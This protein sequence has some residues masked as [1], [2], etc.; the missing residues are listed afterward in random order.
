[1][2]T[3][4]GNNISQT[5]QGLIKLANSTT[6]VTSTTQSFQDG[7]GNNIPIQVSA[8]QV[9]ISGSFFINNVPITNG[10]NGTSGTSGAAGSSGSSGSS[11]ASGSSG[12][13]GSGG[14]SGTS[15]SDGTSGSNGSS[16]SSGSSGSDGSSGTSGS[17]GSDGSSGS[18]GSSG[19]DGSSGTSGSNGTDGTSGSSGV[20]NSFFNYQAKTTITSGNPGSGHIIWDNATQTGS[21]QI[22]ISDIDQQSNNLDVFLSQLKSGSRITLQDKLIQG[23]YQVWDIGTS[24]DNTSYWS[25]PVT[26]V[27]STYQFTNNEDLLF[28]ITTTPSG[29]SGSSGTAGTSGTSPADL[30]RA[31][32]I[33]TGSIAETQSITGSLIISG[34]N[35]T[36]SGSLDINGT[37]KITGSLNVSGS[38]QYDINLNGQMLISNMDTNSTRAP[39]IFLSG[40]GGNTTINR[41]S[42]ATTNTTFTA[43]LNPFATFA[44]KNATLDEIGFTVDSGSVSGWTKGPAIYT[45]DPTDNFPAMIGF[46]DKA[47]YTDG[48]ITLLKNTDITGSLRTTTGIIIDNKLSISNGNNSLLSNIAIGSSSLSIIPNTRTNN[49]AIGER[50]LTVAYAAF[51]NTAIS[52]GRK[53]ENANDNTLIGYGAGDEIQ[54]CI[55]ENTT[56]GVYSLGTLISGSYNTAI[57]Y[58]AGYEAKGDNNL[59]LGHRAGNLSTGSNTLI[60]DSSVNGRGNN[61]SLIYG[62]FDA[63]PNN[64]ILRINAA[65]TLNGNT[66]ITGSLIVS[67]SQSIT[68][69]INITG[70]YL[71][72]GVPFSGGTSG[73]SGTDGSSGTSG[74][75]GTSGTSGVSGSSGT[76]GDSLFALTGSVWN[77]TNNVGITGSLTI[78]GSQSVDLIVTGSGR[79]VS[80]DGLERNQISP[81]SFFVDTSNKS[82]VN[83]ENYIFGS[84]G[85]QAGFYLGVYE[86]VGFAQDVE[87]RIQ[88][89][90]G[91]GIVLSDW[92]NVTAGDYVPFMSIAPN[93]GN[94]PAPQF[95]R[96]V[97][98]TGSLDVN[99]SIIMSDGVNSTIISYT[100]VGDE[101]SLGSS[102]IQIPNSL[103]TPSIN[104]TTGDLYIDVANPGKLLLRG[105]QGI[106]LDSSNGSVNITGSLNITGSVGITGSVQGNVNSL[107]IAS[108]T[109][110]LNL[111][112]GNFFTLQLVSGSA[113]HIL[114]SNI[115][116]GQTIN[117][118]LST[119]GSGTVSFPTTVKQ[120]SGSA[121]VP[122]T[123]TSK[124]I[125]TL[126][127]F[128]SSSL[129]LA[130]VKNLI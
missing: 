2:S 125:I 39:R 13:T 24:T 36:I 78:S 53:L 86:P 19:S 16:G 116:Q 34:S 59:F 50:A 93:L 122:T 46:Q 94:N 92:D 108:T 90:T 57:G 127:S 126:I 33:T 106:S 65:T 73:T 49:I 4:F 128:D 23:N 5:Y 6:G 111:N 37:T 22:N 25:Y 84:T 68:G 112:N 42:I 107:S 100:N 70:Q 31:G 20:S 18:S 114:P 7:L 1:M 30:N 14:T 10:T 9:N 29:T 77:T 35:T 3:L 75:D 97:G 17:S 96:N 28:I 95:K 69:S 71:V 104:S 60:I 130:N 27:S 45:N 12:S 72:N 129:Y 67:G 26:L 8:T 74:I 40:S 113:T 101:L 41:S 80:P 66:N 47:R 54:N 55:G 102:N 38:G 123:T 79:F 11:G 118:L 98:I 82:G 109:A 48:R 120:V 103:S 121:Y 15:G 62:T 99:G 43:Q 76:S 32:L 124:D 117:I 61:S 44:F 83:P 87:L 89:D 51:N 115:K 91:S 21:T 81:N 64:Q 110:S 58:A 56:I 85:S 88:V 52:T 119:T 105:N 63:D